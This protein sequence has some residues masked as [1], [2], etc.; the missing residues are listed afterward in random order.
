MIAALAVAAGNGSK[1]A[2][3]VLETGARPQSR[4]DAGAG[5]DAEEL[6]RLFRVPVEKMREALAAG[7][8]PPRVSHG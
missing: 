5:A 4:R 7:W 2:M 3:R 6:A 1:E 8:V